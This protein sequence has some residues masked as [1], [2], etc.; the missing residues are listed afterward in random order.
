M[1]V[2]VCTR[3][4]DRP[5]LLQFT[6]TPP[7]PVSLPQGVSSL[8]VGATIVFEYCPA[9]FVVVLQFAPVEGISMEMTPF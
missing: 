7:E 8:M 3:Y 9:E 1:V 4:P 5:P 2:N 6:I